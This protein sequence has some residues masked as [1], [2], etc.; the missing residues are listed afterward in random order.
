MECNPLVTVIV[1]IYN[2]EK[3][4][5]GC[6][7]SLINQ[8]YRNLEILLIN[9]GS[10]DGSGEIC[11][12]YAGRDPRIR[13]FSQENQ[14]QSAARNVGLDN[15]RGEYLTFVDADDCI[16]LAYIEILLNTLIEHQVPIAVCSLDRLRE[17]ETGKVTVYSCE[18]IPSRKISRNQVFDLME[19]GEKVECFLITAC[20][21][22]EREIFGMLRFP[23]G[24]ICEDAFIFHQ[25]YDQIKYVCYVDLKLYHY[26]L[27]NN[28]TTRRNGRQHISKDWVE[29][30][31]KR[32]EYFQEYGE[33][34][35][36]RIT[37]DKIW[38]CAKELCEHSDMDDRQR[39]KYMR[40]I[41]GEI[42]RITGRRLW[43]LKLNLYLLAPKQYRFIKNIYRRGAEG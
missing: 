14:G 15:M 30:I 4:L 34:K 28:S 7:N 43:P 13:L 24:K 26:T 29:A 33:E 22:Y 38:R 12:E 9:D 20:K 35:Y 17:D 18:T 32:L 23:I 21:L 2:A 41:V 36:I 11:C 42:K 5:I 39:Q 19:W 6:L 16:D 25:I 27:S 3:Y 1:P 31:I 8:T 40:Q 37:A 10:T